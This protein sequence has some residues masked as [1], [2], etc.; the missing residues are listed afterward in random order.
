MFDVQYMDSFHWAYSK[1]Q[2]SHKIDVRNKDS[3]VWKMD[4]DVQKMDNDVRNIDS[5]ARKRDKIPVLI[6]DIKC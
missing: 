4:N 1:N 6:L 3:D 5:D 2:C